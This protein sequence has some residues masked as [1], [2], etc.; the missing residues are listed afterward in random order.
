M[1]KIHYKDYFEFRAD[2]VAFLD[3]DGV[4]NVDTSYVSK[5]ED[6]KIIDSAIEAV[7]LM[8]ESGFAVVVV[9]NQSG[10]ARGFFSLEKMWEINDYLVNQFAENG[11]YIHSVYC[12]P[13]L[14]TADFK[15][16]F[17]KQTECRKPGNAMLEHFLARADFSR[18]KSIIFG[19]SERDLMAGVKSKLGNLVAVGK[20][21]GNSN[22]AHFSIHSLGDWKP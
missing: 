17:V 10:V 20:L 16:E 9:T 11:A 1:S 7:K 2:K 5:I 8:N 3:R 14:N 4:L 12:S 18:E 22:L 19:D 21:F 15:N 6:L 13:Y